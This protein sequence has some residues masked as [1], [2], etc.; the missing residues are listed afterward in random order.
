[1]LKEEEET[2]GTYEYEISQDE[3]KI[4]STDFFDKIEKKPPVI[5]CQL[6]MKDRCRTGTLELCQD[7]GGS[8]I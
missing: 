1:M 4:N 3:K 5:F 7:L 2:K 8:R 6:G